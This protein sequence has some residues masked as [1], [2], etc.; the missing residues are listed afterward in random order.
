IKEGN[1]IVGTRTKVKIVKNK[2]APP[3]KIA[4]FDIIYGEGISRG[5]DVLD[6]AVE[7]D[8]VEKSGSWFSYNGERIGQGREN[9]KKFLQ[10]RP[11]VLDE[12]DQKVRL[13]Y[14]LPVKEP[15]GENQEAEGEQAKA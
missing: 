2:M 5:G 3:F 4:E 14:G 10:D 13:A 7:M 9:V 6:L 15:K 12:L 8:I 1:D 11:E